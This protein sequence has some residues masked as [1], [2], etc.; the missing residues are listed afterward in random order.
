MNKRFSR[1]EIDS[2]L[3]DVE[4]ISD[5]MN[6]FQSNAFNYLIDYVEMGDDGIYPSHEGHRLLT[7]CVDILTQYLWDHGWR[8]T[9]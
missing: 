9:K 7:L 2:L 6:S 1:L 5:E 8:P 4:T 3:K